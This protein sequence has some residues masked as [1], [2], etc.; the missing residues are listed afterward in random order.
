MKSISDAW[1]LHQETL[2]RGLDARARAEIERAFF[3]GA[4]SVVDDLQD[5]NDAGLSLPFHISQQL[6]RWASESIGHHRQADT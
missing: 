3:A 5:L 4:E 2:P 6:M 1:H